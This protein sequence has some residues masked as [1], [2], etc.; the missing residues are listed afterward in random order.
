MKKSS[1]LIWGIAFLIFGIIVLLKALGL[2]DVGF[3]F[4]VHLKL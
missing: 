1:G 4:W 3:F 2:F